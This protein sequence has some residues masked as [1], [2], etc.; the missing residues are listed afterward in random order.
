MIDGTIDLRV[1]LWGFV[2]DSVGQKPNYTRIARRHLYQ[3][4]RTQ[5]G[6]TELTRAHPGSP[7]LNRRPFDFQGVQAG[8]RHRP[9]V[10]RAGNVADNGSMVI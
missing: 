5:P 8:W 10:S 2:T 7:E 3:Q 4:S 6:S 9:D 1:V